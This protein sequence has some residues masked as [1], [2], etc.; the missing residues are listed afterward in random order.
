[1]TADIATGLQ[2]AERIPA[3]TAHIND[4]TVQ[5]DANAPFGG[6]RHSGNSSRFGTATANI[7]AY[8]DTRW[9]TARAT[10]PNYTH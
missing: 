9:I 8:T 1:M 6:V 3:G 7:E 10:V 4:H 5:D 2:M